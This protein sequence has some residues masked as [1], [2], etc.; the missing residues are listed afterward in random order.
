MY[1]KHT[2]SIIIPVYNEEF[3]IEECLKSIVNQTYENIIEILVIDGMSTDSTRDILKSF[4][5]EK[6]VLIDN[7]K[8][9]QSA[10]LNKGIKVA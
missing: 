5:N 9:I 3:Y 2:V 10:A 7:E 8:K 6:I 1:N 4:Q